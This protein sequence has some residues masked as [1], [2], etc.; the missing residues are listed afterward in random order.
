MIG[1]ILIAL[2]LTGVIAAIVAGLVRDKKHGKSSCGANCAH[3]A[4]GGSCHKK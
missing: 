2:L 3:C 4:M 1:T